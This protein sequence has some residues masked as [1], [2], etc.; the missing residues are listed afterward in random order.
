MQT[1]AKLLLVP[2]TLLWKVFANYLEEGVPK[3]IIYSSKQDYTYTHNITAMILH[4]FSNRFKHLNFWDL[5]NFRKKSNTF[6]YLPGGM[7][8]LSLTESQRIFW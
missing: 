3:V 6:K 7:R 8:T 5:E 1:E 2:D 4:T